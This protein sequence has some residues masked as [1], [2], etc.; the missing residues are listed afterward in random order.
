MRSAGVF[1]ID[2]PWYISNAHVEM[3]VSIDECFVEATDRNT[4]VGVEVVG[5]KS[6]KF[7][8]VTVKGFTNQAFDVLGDA[9]EV[10]ADELT[11]E[12]C[13]GAALYVREQGGKGLAENVRINKLNL[14]SHNTA[15]KT[16]VVEN[17]KSLN[18]GQINV[19]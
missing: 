15:Q 14:L 6:A 17:A 5:I 16:V 13:K 1:L 11:V 2:T 4:N 19:K 8:K 12:D 7:G 3:N 18:I 9:K 10:S